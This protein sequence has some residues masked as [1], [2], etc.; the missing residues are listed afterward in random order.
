MSRHRARRAA[1]VAASRAAAV[2]ALLASCVLAAAAAAGDGARA[3][4][5]R[6]ES[7]GVTSAFER[8]PPHPALDLSDA[9]LR[10]AR[11]RGRALLEAEPFDA[12]EQVHLLPGGPNEMVVVW[13]S[14]SVADVDAVVR[15]AEEGGDANDDADL[16]RRRSFRTAEVHTTAYTAQLCLGES[17]SV[18]PAMGNR[19]PVD[20]DALVALANTSAWAPRDASNFFAADGVDDVIPAGWFGS[21]PWEKAICLEYNNPDSQYQSP[22]IRTARLVG[23]R[24]GATYRYELPGDEE[25]EEEAD[26]TPSTEYSKRRSDRPGYDDEPAPGGRT[27]TALP[28]PGSLPETTGTGKLVLGVVGDTGQTEVTRAVLEHLGAATESSPRVDLVLHTGDVSYADGH[29]PRWDSFGRLSEALF[30]RVPLLTTPGNHDVTLNGLESTAYRAR[31]P[32]PHVRSKSPSPDWWSLDVGLAH[33]IGVS[34]YAPAGER[35]EVR[36]LRQANGMERFGLDGDVATSMRR[37]LIND[38]AAVDRA[39]TPWVVVMF[40]V[41]WYNSNR[42]HFREAERHR[43]ALERVLYDGGVDFVL[44]GHV[45][46][47]ER[48]RNVFDGKSDPCG[49]VHL[50][51]GDGGNYEGPYGGG[52]RDPQPEWSAFREGSFGAGRLVLENATDATWTWHRT[53]CVESGG[54]TRFNETW[55]VPVDE[56]SGGGANGSGSPCKSSNDVSAQAMA[57]VD[58]ARFA[59]DP[60]LCPNR[61][62]SGSRERRDDA[63]DENDSRDG[64]G[65]SSAVAV[66][67]FLA[68]GWAATAAALAWALA[69]LRRERRGASAFR[70]AQLQLGDDDNL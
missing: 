25:E 52:W 46:A 43:W 1:P 48:S 21:P 42:G 63:R 12:P 59:R 6:S 67:A 13:A 50:V 28:A 53:T 32:S 68:V 15:Y 62:G 10:R 64:G 26:S 29:A 14:A 7:R 45:H 3:A 40:H 58:F 33:V 49:P 38:L 9:R 5:S 18:D 39:K 22:F 16:A 24:P 30:S 60:A 57:P 70:H 8:P 37:W 51:V 31:Y 47:Y 23:L 35:R 36:S 41:P 11:P 55:Y 56:P 20:L 54:V 69:A 65:G 19:H 44:N 4:P 27:F 34:S 66:E 2:A 61:A 17:M